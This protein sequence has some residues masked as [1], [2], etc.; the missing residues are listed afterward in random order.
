MCMQ[1]NVFL[2]PNVSWLKETGSSS[3]KKDGIWKT[4]TNMNYSICF[5]VVFL[6]FLF[7]LFFLILFYFIY[8]FIYLFF[9]FVV[10]R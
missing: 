1:S 9:C 8:L 6:L 2:V 4:A 7:F 10:A 3:E 5:A